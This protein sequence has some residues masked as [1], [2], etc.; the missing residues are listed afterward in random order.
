[1]LDNLVKEK[2]RREGVAE[3]G[4]NPDTRFPPPLLMRPQTLCPWRDGAVWRWE[5]WDEGR[6]DGLLRGR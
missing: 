6:M 1:M 5:H 2:R 4:I 3:Q